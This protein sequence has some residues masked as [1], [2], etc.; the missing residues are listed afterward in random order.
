MSIVFEKNKSSEGTKQPK[1]LNFN[2]LKTNLWRRESI[3]L[4]NKKS[5]KFWL[6]LKEDHDWSEKKKSK[7]KKEF[8][9]KNNGEELKFWLHQEESNSIVRSKSSK[10]QRDKTHTYLRNKGLK[11]S[12]KKNSDKLILRLEA[13]MTQEM[14]ERKLNWSN[15]NSWMKRFSE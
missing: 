2:K 14:N 1:M 15:W 10:K 4:R 9:N 11:K 6:K 7:H 3:G 12:S 13:S 8:C 5:M